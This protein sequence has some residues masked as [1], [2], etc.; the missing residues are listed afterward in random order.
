MTSSYEKKLKLMRKKPKKEKLKACVPVLDLKKARNPSVKAAYEIAHENNQKAIEADKGVNNLVTVTYQ[1]PKVTNTFKHKPDSQRVV[2]NDSTKNST[3]P[4]PAIAAQTRPALA[5]KV[6]D[7]LKPPPITNYMSVKIETL[8][9]CLEKMY[10]N[11]LPLN[12]FT[13]RYF[14]YFHFASALL[15]LSP[16]L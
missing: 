11:H 15:R 10:H 1:K 9:N 13:S 8:M 16:H 4:G 3:S 2:L 12:A 5:P 7:P 14:F 6:P